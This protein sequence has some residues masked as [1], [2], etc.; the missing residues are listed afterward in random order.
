VRT[1]EN[2]LAGKNR[3]DRVLS[4]AGGEAFPDKDNGGD[5]IPVLKLARC[6]EKET[7]G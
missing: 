7:V 6:V 4:A 5:R 3:L 2:W 1:E